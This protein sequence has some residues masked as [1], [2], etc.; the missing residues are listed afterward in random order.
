[1]EKGIGAS[2]LEGQDYIIS[3]ITENDIYINNLEYATPGNSRKHNQSSKCV[4]TV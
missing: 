4:E 3:S 1:M 2:E